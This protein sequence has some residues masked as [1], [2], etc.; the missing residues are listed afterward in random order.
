MSLEEIIKQ[1]LS[2]RPDLTR[3]ETLKMI[4]KKKKGAGE[5]FTDEAAA[6][7]V[8]SE[9]GVEIFREPLRLEVLIRDLVSGLSDVTVSGRVIM[10]HP[11]KTYT[12]SDRTEG[13]FA[14]LLIADKSGTLKLIL[15]DDKTDLVETGKVKQGQI[16][17]VSH[18]Y[19]REGLD[20]KLELH[21]GLRGDIQIS[22]PD[23]VD[24]EYPLITQFIEKLKVT[25]I[26]KEDGPVV[27]E[28]TIATTPVIREVVTSRNEKV[29]VA[30]FELRDETGEIRVSAWRKLAEVAK[31]LT[32]GT[33][34]KIRNAYVRK[35]FADQLELTSRAFTSIEVLTETG[36]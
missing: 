35:G 1:I 23:A 7:I 10:L 8:A 12:R 22:P 30:S 5:F 33:R 27:V 19:V 4:E 6:R 31:D 14:R 36:K 9:L 25:E 24:S 13:K 15:W 26:K 11:P 20:G 2:S 34:I 17:K 3:E 29:A 18:G 16:I 21:V 28:G 32:V